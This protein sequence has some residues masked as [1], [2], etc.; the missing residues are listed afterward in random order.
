LENLSIEAAQ[1]LREEHRQFFKHH[2][3]APIA[4]RIQKLKT[5]ARVLDAQEAKILNALQKDLKKPEFE[6]FTS[7]F[8]MVRKEIQSFIKHLK[9]WA[10]PK[11][12]AGSLLNFPSQDFILAEPYGTVLLISPWNYPFQLALIP[13]IGAVAAGNTVVVKPSESAPHTSALLGTPM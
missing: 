9:N 8:V 12:V 3:S 11:R 10:A 6:S 4:V 7:E 5:L 13:L 2:K 1:G